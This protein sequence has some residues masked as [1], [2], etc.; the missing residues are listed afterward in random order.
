ML[1]WQRVATLTLFYESRL[2]AFCFDTLQ[3][4]FWKPLSQGNKHVWCVNSVESKNFAGAAFLCVCVCL[5]WEDLAHLG[6][7]NDACAFMRT[8]KEIQTLII[9]PTFQI[10][11]LRLYNIN[12]SS[13]WVY[14]YSV[15]LWL[16]FSVATYPLIRTKTNPNEWNTSTSAWH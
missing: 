16:F 2:G 1:S 4:A 11:F 12:Q 6:I 10:V 8:R 5:M 7:E 9:R 15:F 14:F 13:E 3:Y